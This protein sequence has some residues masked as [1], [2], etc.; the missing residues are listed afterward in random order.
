MALVSGLIG[1][2][3]CRYLSRRAASIHPQICATTREREE[4]TRRLLDGALFIADRSEVAIGRFEWGVKG[5]IQF[6]YPT[7]GRRL[8]SGVSTE[9]LLH[10]R[11]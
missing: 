9:R 8:M 2:F 5:N 11:A 6:P 4:R 10:Q 3:L 1:A 7:D